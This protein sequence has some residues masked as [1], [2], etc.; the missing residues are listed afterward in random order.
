MYFWRT[1]KKEGGWRWKDQQ[2]PFF[3]CCLRFYSLLF[4]LWIEQHFLQFNII[5]TKQ[6]EN[7]RDRGGW[8]E[9]W[10]GAE[11]GA[12]VSSDVKKATVA[13]KYELLAKRG[14]CVCVCALVWII[15]PQLHV[16]ALFPWRRREAEKWGLQVF[17]LDCKEFICISTSQSEILSCIIGEP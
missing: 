17:R 4:V 1:L 6:N 12:S 13:C 7:G 9:G 2:S 10:G 8:W 16:L 5:N 11:K 15:W 14:V 3:S